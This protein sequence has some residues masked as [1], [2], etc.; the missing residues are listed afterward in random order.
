MQGH[1]I[2]LENVET[3]I[4]GDVSKAGTFPKVAQYLASIKDDYIGRNSS[5]AASLFQKQ[6][7]CFVI[8]DGEIIKS[9]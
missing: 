7:N 8:V 6:N 1:P 4:N 9:Q 5:S 2:D 3:K